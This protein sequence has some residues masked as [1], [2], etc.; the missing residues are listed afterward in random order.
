MGDRKLDPQ[1]SRAADIYLIRYADS[2]LYEQ[3]SGPELSFATDPS[4]LID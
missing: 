2:A 4:Y 1:G 3:N